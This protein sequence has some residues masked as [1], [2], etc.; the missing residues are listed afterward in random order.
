MIFG[1]VQHTTSLCSGPQ[2]GAGNRAS[3]WWCIG[4]HFNLQSYEEYH[5]WVCFM[6]GLRSYF[7]YTCL[8]TL[9]KSSCNCRKLEKYPLQNIWKK[10]SKNFETQ[11]AMHIFPLWRGSWN[12]L[13]LSVKW[14]FIVVYLSFD[15]SFF[16][17]IPS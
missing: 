11:L 10:R 6:Y 17:H 14:L 16:F 3:K 4:F 13:G 8:Y 2:W 7:H 1:T 15:S 12:L 9:W 5:L